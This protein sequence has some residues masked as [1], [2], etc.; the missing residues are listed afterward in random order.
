MKSSVVAFP[1]RARRVL[2]IVVALLF[3]TGYAPANAQTLN[4]PLSGK[5]VR[6]ITTESLFHTLF[7]DFFP[8]DDATTYVQTGDIP[9]MWLRDSS[10]QTIPY[11]RFQQ[12]FPILRLRIAGV[13]EHNARAITRDAYA[14]AVQADYH[15]WERKWEIDSLAWPVLLAQVY[16][17]QT[18]DRTMYTP[19]LHR[20]LSRIVY[21]YGCEEHH[22]RCNAYKYPYHVYTD[23]RYNDGTGLIWSAFRPSDDAVQ[24]RFNIPQNMIATIALEDIAELAEDGYGDTP[25]AHRARALGMRVLGGIAQYGRFYNEQRGV[26]MYAYETDGLGHYNLM[27][28]ANIPNL[29]TLPYLSWSSSFDPTYLATRAFALSP[30]NP[31]YF[32]GRYA[33]GLGSPHTPYGFV[34]PLGIIGRA[35]TATS[36]AEVSTNLTML[37][38]TDSESG[39]IHESF[40]PDGYWRYTRA[41]FGWANALYAELVFRS[42]AG[43]S[44]TPF[45]SGGRTMMPFEVRSKTPVLVPTIVQVSNTSELMRTLGRLLDVGR[46]AAIGQT[47]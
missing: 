8:E 37:A 23:D 26:W 20:A 34:W 19:A 7:R 24:Y 30:A 45:L 36:S 35:L 13:I 9:A 16:I 2:A 3:A 39:M 14:N 4:V 40:Y 43:F 33:Q 22:A 1:D 6:Y 47:P 41:E 10:E 21:T 28:D 44:S 11:V 12:A 46:A 5:R 42:V 31:W 32:T 29:T 17:S 27:D 38:E 15:I 18:K 25:L